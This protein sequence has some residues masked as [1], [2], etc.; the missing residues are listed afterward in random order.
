MSSKPRVSREEKVLSCV[1][2]NTLSMLEL[3]EQ[4]ARWIDAGTIAEQLGMD[5]TNV[6]RELNEL[7]KKG[8]LIK[9]QGKPTLYISRSAVTQKY[10]EV[11]FPS[12]LPKGSKLSDIYSDSPMPPEL[13]HKP[14]ITQK[15][16]PLE[17]RVGAYGTLQ[18][19]VR[20]ASAAAMYPTHDLHTL[21]TGNVGVGKAILAHDMYAHAVAKGSMAE[22]APFISVNCREQK[23][24]PQLLLIRLFGCTREAAPKDE[25]ARRGL[26]ERAAGGVLCLVGI[27]TLPVVVHDALITLLE[28]HTYSRVGESS[29]VRYCKTMII[30]ISTEP[31]GSPTIAS[32]QQRFSV[33]IHIPD[34]DEWKPSELA[35][36]LIQCFQKEAEST[37]ISFRIRRDVFSSFLRAS[38]VGNLGE[39]TSSARTACALAYMEA[40]SENNNAKHVELTLH[41]VPAEVIRSIHPNPRRDAQIS[42]FLSETELEYLSFTPNGYSSNRYPS[43]QL[44][45]LMHFGKY[46]RETKPLSPAPERAISSTESFFAQLFSQACSGFDELNGLFGRELLESAHKIQVLYP[47]LSYMFGNPTN[48]YVFLNCLSLA[49]GGLLPPIDSERSIYDELC[50]SCPNEIRMASSIS[51]II[52]AMNIMRSRIYLSICMRMCKQSIIGGIPVVA[53]MHGEG[54]ARSMADYVN[55]AMGTDV[56]TGISYGEDISLEVVV[57]EVSAA[58]NRMDAGR[59]VLLAVDMEPLPQLQTMLQREL[60]A[61]FRLIVCPGLPALLRLS[62]YAL[63]DDMNI[64]SVAELMQLLPSSDADDSSFIGRTFDELLT[65]SLTFLN[66]KKAVDTLSF[67]LNAILDELGVIRSN[68]LLIKFVFHGAH[69]TERLILG[70][71]LRYEGLRNFINQ[72]S[73]LMS[74]LERHMRYV[75]EVFGVSIPTSELAYIAEIILPYLV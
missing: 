50:E 9:V 6:S 48:Y 13:S 25:K 10:P 73:R 27:E 3:P 54:I 52:S 51:S 35:E 36:L 5:R 53:V 74:C 7:Y 65:P 47:E 1:R 15:L 24:N 30:G 62:R 4:S 63:S 67:A 64:E 56:V 21:I 26:I 39:I 44:T 60:G 66:P 40:L 59:G 38:Y 29:A 28:K 42:E 19:A 12:T 75:A 61:A 20:H 16:T 31:L 23:E 45:E 34:V 22:D 2:E 11:F 70:D 8:L 37:G 55:R 46:S 68:E 33:Q 18:T 32:L 69:M 57:T 58:I 43:S 14:D 49:A 17:N 71:S 72:N 41:N